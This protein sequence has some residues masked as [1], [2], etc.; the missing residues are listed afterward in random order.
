MVLPDTVYIGI[1]AIL[2][3]LISVSGVWLTNRSSI[4][5]L[6]IQHNNE[7]TVKADE[8][9]RE[10]LEELYILID[11]WL[12]AM[13]SQYLMLSSVMKGDIDYNQYLDSVIEKGNQQNVDFCRFEMIVNIYSNDLEP[14]YQQLMTARDDINKIISSHKAAYKSG[15]FN[16]EKYITPFNAAMNKLEKL[17]S[18]FKKEIAKHVKSVYGLD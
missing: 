12:N 10:K 13:F 3:A 17:G 7:K 16:G 6:I 18:S 15:D 1:G 9:K 14:Y 4:K 8:L 5:Q 11:N 2:G